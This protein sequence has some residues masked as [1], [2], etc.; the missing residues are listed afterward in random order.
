ML[1]RVEFQMAILAV[2][3][4]YNPGSCRNS[5]NRMRHPPRWEMRLDSLALHEEQSRI[6]EQTG[7][8]P[9]FC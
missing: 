9:R 8:E 6:P 5:R 4:E 2:T 7:K 1:N 3:R